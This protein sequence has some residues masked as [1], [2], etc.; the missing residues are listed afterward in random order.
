MRVFQRVRTV[1]RVRFDAFGEVLADRAGFRLGRIGRAHDF[2]VLQ[3]GVFAFQNLHDHRAGGHEFAQA[4]EERARLVNVVEALG[5]R[6]GKLHALGGDDA[7]A[8]L[9]K[10]VNNGAGVVTLGG[11]RLD[12]GKRAFNGHNYAPNGEFAGLI[13]AAWLEGKLPIC[14]A[15]CWSSTTSQSALRAGKSLRARALRCLR[16]GAWGWWGATARA[17]PPCSRRS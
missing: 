3:D 7:K 1:D 5:L 8:R 16:G 4:F 2:A 6:R 9:L 14:S 12:D 15:P 10:T 13:G 17:N 11:V